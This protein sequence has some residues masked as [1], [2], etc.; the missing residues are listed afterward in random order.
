[1]TDSYLKTLKTFTLDS[2]PNLD[3]AV[4]GALERFSKK[5]LPMFTPAAVGKRPFIIGSGNA[6]TTGRIL[7]RAVDAE[8]ADESTY[9]QEL[10]IG[11]NIDSIVIISASGGKHAVGIAKE[12]EQ[13]N[14]PLWLLTNNK[15]APAQKHINSRRI[16]VF[17]KNREPY[18]YNV[19]TYFSMIY[20]ETRENPET[21]Y[22]FITSTVEAEVPE[23][24]NEYDSFYFIIPSEFHLARDM[25]LTKF[26]ELFGSQVTGRV[27][28]Y[29]ET[30]HAKTVVPSER[31]LFISFGEEQAS[32]G[33]PENRITISLP[34]GT[35]YGAFLAVGY[36]VIGRIQS[37]MP[38]YF[39]ENIA[40]YTKEASRFFNQDIQP[41]V[42]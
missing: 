32:F 5:S 19:S 11:K 1:M 10:S 4:L 7:F 20:S 2:L 31:E 41:I 17:P 26:D 25:F 14:L 30:K 6:L 16:F 29:G 42:E 37:Q 35:G 39:K 38:N 18:T 12:L 23:N 40:R 27:F 24:L 9:R 3:V 8:F 22:A 28:T 13:N 15:D 34:P 33:I 21:T 36:Y